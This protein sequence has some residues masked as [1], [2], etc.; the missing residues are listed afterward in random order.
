MRKAAS[1]LI[2]AETFLEIST[3]DS[4]KIA[5]NLE[6]LRDIRRQGIIELSHF[7]YAMCE[8]TLIS[9]LAVTISKVPANGCFVFAS[10]IWGY[11]HHLSLLHYILLILHIIVLVESLMLII[12]WM[13][14]I[15]V[16]MTLLLNLLL[17]FIPSFK[18]IR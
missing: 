3:F 16:I 7:L 8:M 1:M 11:V 15:V 9:K 10:I 4:L 5:V 17:R 14:I 18:G 12:L 2:F 6:L 13:T